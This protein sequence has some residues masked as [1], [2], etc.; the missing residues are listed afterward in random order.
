MGP[1]L[2]R[3]TTRALGNGNGSLNTSHRACGLLPLRT[4]FLQ[5]IPHRRCRQNWNS[6]R[7]DNHHSVAA[8]TRGASLTRALPNVADNAIAFKEEYT[9]DIEAAEE[10]SLKVLEWPAVC[11]QVACF[12]GTSIAA[13]LV[14]SGQL[15]RGRS[16]EESELLLQ[17]TAE[18]LA[19]K[20]EVRGCLDIRP[21][22]EAA[23]A[24]ACLNA[25]Q[26]EGVA[27]TLE[28]AFAL[29]AAAT[30]TATA[31]LCHSGSSSSSSSGGP[32]TTT[33][34]SSK[35]STKPASSPAAAAP[36][37][38]S[39]SDSTVS[40]P[41]AAAADPAAASESDPAVAPAAAAPLFP[42]LAALAAGISEE[43]RILL[44]AIR[45][46][47]EHGGVCDGA[48]EALAALRAQ[49]RANKEQLRAEVERWAR[50][51]VTRG[52][53]EPGAVALVRGRLCVGVRAG[54]QG[55]LPRGSVRLGASSSG[56]TLY[57]EPQ[58]CVALNNAEAL[59]AEQEEREAGR[60]LGLLSGMLGSRAPQVLSLLSAAVQL[61]VVAARAAHACWLGAVRPEFVAAEAEEEEGE[62]EEEGCS[63]SSS[64]CPP[65]H[66]P[67][68][69]HPVLMQRG[70]PP[71][72]HP[73]SIDDNR[74]D[75]DFQAAPA[76]E[77]M[78]RRAVR[79]EGPASELGGSSGS[80]GGGAAEGGAGAEGGGG[81]GGGASLLPKPLDLRVPAGRRVVTITGPNT[82]GKTVTLK[83]A[84]LLVLMAQAGLYLPC[85]RQQEEEEGRQQERA[86]THGSPAPAAA[87]AAAPLPSSHT[88]RLVWFDRVLAD[89]G[90]SQSLQQNLSTFSGHIRRIKRI[91]R[92]ASRRSLVLLDEVGSGTDPLEGAALARAVLDTLAGQARLTLATSHHAELK[93]AAEDDPRFINCCM[94]FDTATLRPTYQLRWGAAGAS[95]ALDIAEALG[96]DSVVVREARALASIMAAASASEATDGAAASSS[97]SSIASSTSFTSSPA[98]VGGG[99]SSRI[100]GVARSLVRQL[101]ETRAE[102]AAEQVLRA[103]RAEKQAR[104]QATIQ[105][106]REMELQLKATPREIVLERDRLAVEVQTALDAFAAGL[107]P[108]EP[109]EQALEKIEAL[110]PREVAALGGGRSG[111]SG[112]SR[113][114]EG[115]SGGGEGGDEGEQGEEDGDE[116]DEEKEDEEEDGEAL[117]PGD[118][119]HVKSYGEM[120][121]AQVVSVKGEHVTVRFNTIMFSAAS[122]FSRKAR[123]V[124]LHRRQV[125]RIQSG[126]SLPLGAI[127]W[128]DS[129]QLLTSDVSRALHGEEAE[130]Q[131]RDEEQDEEDG[132]QDGS[133]TAAAAAAAG[134]AGGQQQGEQQPQLLP[135]GAALLAEVAATEEDLLVGD[136]GSAEQ[137]EVVSEGLVLEEEGEGEGEEEGGRRKGSSRRGRGKAAAADVTA[138]VTASTAK[139]RRRRSRG[140]KEDEEDEEEGK[141][142]GE[143]VCDGKRAPAPAAATVAGGAAGRRWRRATATAAAAQQAEVEEAQAA[144]AAAEAEAA[145]TIPAGFLV[146]EQTAGNTLDVAG[147]VPELAAADLEDRLRS[148]APGSVLF[149]QHGMGTGAVRRAVH[150]LLEK[151][152]A[153]KGRVRQWG[154]A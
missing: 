105:K 107:K 128:M 77:L 52:A 47:I 65:L 30:A 75:R 88:P 53:A 154:E 82:G 106:V 137:T 100:A 58:P 67:G 130:K 14:A 21:A 116:D 43:E 85:S 37:G 94:T 16:R 115:S 64:S 125:R 74:F 121:D 119:V 18:A 113:R 11:K 45:G 122:A 151:R 59:L 33:V 56:A 19:A 143:D 32:N 39:D 3:T 6:L 54:R 141:E 134:T 13:E 127:P 89:I 98:L 57:L 2:P 44:R 60:V 10:E 20:L 28:A 131:E 92:S 62:G 140:A 150:A 114:R 123:P 84:G 109:V 42:H 15:P 38:D 22:A 101:E 41:P 96:F 51:L 99:G 86:V 9:G 97:S 1:I 46:C 110:I 48:S 153:P 31:P 61:D 120:G 23:A 126:S 149:V 132:K 152:R 133:S 27:A 145:G 40:T 76:W 49:R 24:G 87:T 55:E 66:L 68:A 118:T 63:S 83:A 8:G 135:P 80:G 139:T 95:N 146:P 103:R 144:A 71:L 72:P 70:L 117:R 36:P 26:L 147:E 124:K 5:H 7:T 90:D 136:W 4:C 78:R 73:P 17:Q 50:Q 108:Q 112:K 138:D 25:R 148:A 29:K 34:S 102:V 93:R 111:A 12:C 142:G 129:Y 91:L 104:L 79:P 35:R 69:M 81:G